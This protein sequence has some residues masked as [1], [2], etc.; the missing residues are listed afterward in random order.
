MSSSINK[1]AAALL[2][3]CVASYASFDGT[4]R[5]RISPATHIETFISTAVASLSNPTS[6]STTAVTTTTAG[7]TMFGTTAAAPALSAASAAL[8]ADAATAAFVTDVFYTLMRYNALL[9]R[10]SES[11]L[12]SS[13]ATL[14]RADKRPFLVLIAIAL[15]KLSDLGWEQFQSLLGAQPGHKVVPF[16][17]AFFTSASLQTWFRTEASTFFDIVH[18]DNVL[19]P[20][21]LA[22]ADEA[23]ALADSLRTADAHHTRAAANGNNTT[24]GSGY[25]GAGVTATLSPSKTTVPVPFNLSEAKPRKQAPHAVP[26]EAVPVLFQARPVPA[27]L[28]AT[29]LQ[30]IEAERAAATVAVAAATAD[31]YVGVDSHVPTASDERLAAAAAARAEKDAAAA[32]AA[33]AAEAAAAAAAE[34]E[35]R[36][37]KAQF[38]HPAE[39]VK[40]TAA[41]MLR[42]EALYRRQQEERIESLKRFAT[43]LKDTTEYDAWRV[44]AEAEAEAERA[45]AVEARKEDAAR[46][47]V[48]AQEAVKK[49]MAEVQELAQQQRK[50]ARAA[51]D[52]RVAAEE[53]AVAQRKER[54]GEIAADRANVAV[55][56]AE[57]RKERGVGAEAL[58]RE[59][60]QNRQR[61]LD[62]R[63]TELAARKEVIRQ[64]QAMEQVAHARARQP[65]E[66]D[67]TQTAGHGF[68]SEM[69]LAELRAKLAALKVENETEASQRRSK[70]AD[71]KALKQAKFE[72]MARNH[73]AIRQYNVEKGDVRREG[74]ALTADAK[75]AVEAAR[76]AAAA[77]AADRLAIEN[78]A[79]RAEAALLLAQQNKVR[80]DEANFQ[81]LSKAAAMQQRAEELRASAVRRVQRE[82]AAEAAAAEA[83]AVDDERRQ[84]A[85]GKAHAQQALS[86]AKAIA[87]MKNDLAAR[88]ADAQR[89]AALE[90]ARKRKMTATVR[91]AR[92]P[93]SLAS[94]LSAS[95]TGRV[96]PLGLAAYSSGAATP[97]SRSLSGAGAGASST[98]VVSTPHARTSAVMAAA[99]ASVLSGNGNGGGAG[100]SGSHGQFNGT[101]AMARTV[102]SV[103]S[104]TGVPNVTVQ[105][106]GSNVSV[107]V[108]RY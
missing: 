18:V 85:L 70:A 65:K 6:S 96:S 25:A 69:S 45:A 58:R 101:G 79:T 52:E 77:V 41:A 51:G 34:A 36:K 74:K 64:I 71:E 59:K 63:A 5:A 19:I 4:A 31:K 27:A 9:L 26:R 22:H 21:L 108:H 55:A 39:S 103:N 100:H 106:S 53:A 73:A 72:A 92:S 28:A 67:P 87:S 20:A 17:A 13:K 29:S 95:S 56:V 81:M 47:L 1:E 30:A 54:A 89:E 68:L 43:E 14:T 44:R 102:R 99:G 42:E 94:P 78:A 82:E 104:N 66:V 80:A 60:E 98:A 35:T 75:A 57:A 12:E 32:A 48:D 8:A 2:D 107:S 23:A 62:E 76:A 49:R 105:S 93:R 84:R 83:V 91:E 46:A 7:G 3:L 33:A 16:L 86:Q 88:H 37:L 90:L 40:L 97:L 11:F 24:L 61:V 10:L 15:W 50:D 38:L